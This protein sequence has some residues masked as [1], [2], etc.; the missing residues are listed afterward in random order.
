VS[1]RVREIGSLSRA[2][3]R[4][5]DAIHTFALY[6]PREFVREGIRSG[7]FS[8]RAASRNE[9]TALFT[10]IYDFTTISEAHAPEQVVA[11]LSGYFDIFAEA[12]SAH[13][14]SI[15][16]FLGDSVFAMW[17]AP[18]ADEEHAADACRCAL[19]VE[20]AL[21]GFNEKQRLE[22]LPEFRTRFGI[23]TGQ[24]V[25][26]SVGAAD[27]LQYTAM[28]DTINVASRLEGMN[29]QYGTT[30]IAS[31]AVYSRCADVI[32]FRPLGT[33]Q[34]KGRAVA[35]ALYEVTGV[36]S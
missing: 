4:A 24:A 34:A 11:M 1:S 27:R 5:R 21:A 35:I 31:D 12:V 18:V 16:Q 29:K 30:I 14:G 22:G 26:G 3:N 28:G 9:V 13:D 2:M 6:V 7:S 17:N 20:Q 10:D 15:I 25:V 36:I 19:A 8:G 32:R 23:H 33:A